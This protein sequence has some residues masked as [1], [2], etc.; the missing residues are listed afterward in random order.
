MEE[1]IRNIY[2]MNI[3]PN[4]KMFIFSVADPN[5]SLKYD[6][7][8]LNL[9]KGAKPNIIKAN[10]ILQSLNSYDK[11]IIRIQE[12]D[13]LYNFFRSSLNRAKKINFKN[14]IEKYPDTDTNNEITLGR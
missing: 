11:K 14:K 12:G 1:R 13:D 4:S 3:G 6:Y 10:N 9:R 7:Y 5:N 2:L 8:L